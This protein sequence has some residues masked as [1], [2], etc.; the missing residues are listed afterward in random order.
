MEVNP[1]ESLGAVIEGEEG[2]FRTVDFVQPLHKP[3]H[4][5][6]GLMLQQVP[7][8]ALVVIPFA[9]LPDLAS[10]EE[11]LL[12]GV[13]PHPAQ[14]HPQVGSLLPVITRHL[15]HQRSLSVDDLVVA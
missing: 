5:G 12:A 11:E 10:L 14:E 3:L 2:R 9:P 8:D 1:L 6:M 13:R 15:V 4:P 7:V